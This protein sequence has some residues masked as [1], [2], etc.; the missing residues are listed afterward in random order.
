MQR[1]ELHPRWSITAKPFCGTVGGVGSLAVSWDG[2]VAW[3]CLGG[4]RPPPTSC[5]GG[6]CGWQLGDTRGAPWDLRD[7]VWAR[8]HRTLDAYDLPLSKYF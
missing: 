7:R 5:F 3:P 1:L 6:L 2:L 8:G 4:K